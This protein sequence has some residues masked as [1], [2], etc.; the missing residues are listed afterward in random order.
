MKLVEH[1]ACERRR[2]ELYRVVR[3]KH[4]G[5][6]RLLKSRHRWE[7]IK[8]DLKEIGWETMDCSYLV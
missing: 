3:G 8:N 1:V 6:K 7:N 2:E 5:T 4:E